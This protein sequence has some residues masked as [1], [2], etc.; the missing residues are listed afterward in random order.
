[1][2]RDEPK[3]SFRHDLGT[4]AAIGKIARLADDGSEIVAVTFED[5]AA[6]VR[7]GIRLRTVAQA[8]ELWRVA[9]EA[10]AAMTGE[11]PVVLGLDGST[12]ADKG[13]AAAK[14][15]DE[16]AALQERDEIF[17]KRFA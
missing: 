10:L 14:L 2:H 15:D 9:G 12:P 11:L 17:A 5:E 16:V 8:A 4:G 3:T 1:M 13:A 7:V 6:S